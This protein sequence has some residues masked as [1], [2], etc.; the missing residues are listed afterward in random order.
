MAQWEQAG[1]GAPVGSQ[2]VP[3]QRRARGLRR[4][5][6]DTTCTTSTGTPACCRYLSSCGESTC[7][8]CSM[9]WAG[10]MSE[11][12]HT[13]GTWTKQHGG[14]KGVKHALAGLTATVV[15]RLR[16]AKQSKS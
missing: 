7:Q 16:L 6:P 3:A 14:R 1:T 10:S 15:G 2:Q 12:A 9:P 11:R 5:A 4:G 8:S 13:S